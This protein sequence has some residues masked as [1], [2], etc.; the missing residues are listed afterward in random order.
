M[1]A[2]VVHDAVS[3]KG[4]PRASNRDVVSSRARASSRERENEQRR[5]G[6]TAVQPFSTFAWQQ[7]TAAFRGMECARLL[8]RRAWLLYGQCTAGARAVTP[9]QLYTYIEHDE[10]RHKSA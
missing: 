5:C 6:A 1:T 9:V 3:R 2:Q 7:A 10:T 4:A 8:P